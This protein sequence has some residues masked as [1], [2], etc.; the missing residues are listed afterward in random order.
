MYHPHG[1]SDQWFQVQLDK[2]TSI[3]SIKIYNRG[4]CCQDRMAG[5]K[6]YLLDVNQNILWTSQALTAAPVQTVTV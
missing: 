5:N 1:R 3:S 2:P 4:D 6:I